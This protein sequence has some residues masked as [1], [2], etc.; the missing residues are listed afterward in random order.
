VGTGSNNTAVL[1]ILYQP[2]F[3]VSQVRNTL[4][5]QTNIGDLVYAIEVKIPHHMLSVCHDSL[6]RPLIERYLYYI[7]LFSVFF[8]TVVML[9]GS[10]IESRTIVKYQ[11][12]MRKQLYSSHDDKLLNVQD[13]VSEYQMQRDMNSTS[14]A[15]GPTTCLNTN[16]NIKSRSKI[17]GSLSTYTA[18]LANGG[19]Q[20]KANQRNGRHLT[21][22]FSTPKPSNPASQADGP[23]GAKKQTLL[24]AKLKPTKE[25]CS[26]T[27]SAN[28]NIS[29]LVSSTCPNQ[30]K[31]QDSVS[32]FAF[33]FLCKTGKNTRKKNTENLIKS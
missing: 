2:D 16:A 4:T 20:T 29:S 5:L 10:L 26:E 22:S 33:I 17:A 31:D 6:P 9:L 11:A 14:S 3:T 12:N 19:N 18:P 27:G 23:S 32:L 1:E 15:N 13:F 24:G 30:D 28:S 25:T 21:K 8:L 7:G